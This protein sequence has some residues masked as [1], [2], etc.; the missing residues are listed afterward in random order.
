MSATSCV[1][2]I[3]ALRALAIPAAPTGEPPGRHVLGYHNM[4]D[5]GGGLFYWDAASLQPDDGG[6]VIVST[7]PSAPPFGRWKR[8]F[9]GPVHAAWWG[10][11]GDGIAND[12]LALQ[13]A[14]NGAAGRGIVFDRP[15]TYAFDPG[16][17]VPGDVRIKNNGATFRLRSS[18]ASPSVAITFKE[19]VRAD[20]VKV[21]VPAG[22]TVS[23]LLSLGNDN[24]IERIELTSDNQQTNFAGDLDGALQIRKQNVRVGTVLSSKFDK[25]VMVYEAS[26]AHIKHVAVHNY[27]LGVHVR[28]S[29][30]IE[31]LSGEITTPAAALFVPGHH[32]LLI[33][34]SND[35]VVSDTVVHDAG[36]HG[37]RVGGNG[38]SARIVLN[39]IQ[40]IRPGGCGLKIRAKDGF[41]VRD[42]QI[43]GLTVVDAAAR[44]TPGL[45]QDGL[46]LENCSYVTA[47][48]VQV[49]A[50]NRA[51]AAHDGIWVT[52]CDFVT[53]NGP[54]VTN[55]FSN[56]IHLK[57]DAGPVNQI[58][59]NN[60]S[61]LFSQ[62]NGIPSIVP[63]TCCATS[64]SCAATYAATLGGESGCRPIHRPSV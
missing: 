7:N 60:P 56:G 19:R 16:L 45:N 38:N 25:G 37:I 9:S 29:S 30:F 44:S 12:T 61:I 10:L 55:V 59:I 41:R 1:Q 40:S 27:V 5:G 53:I 43:N 32:G 4:G 13:S 26:R 3:A 35:I 54:R 64:R 28:K 47:N 42:V 52:G 58:F 17:N 51:Y 18:L 31:L 49:Q 11:I 21:L 6:L 57:D 2:S 48:G 15:Q 22:V 36:K 24:D 14:L 34:D 33:A 63:R 50:E 39:N 8:A 46:R 23:R 62:T 20:L